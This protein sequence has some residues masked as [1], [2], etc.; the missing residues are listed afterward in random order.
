M[1]HA[2][3]TTDGLRISHGMIYYTEVDD[4]P[5]RTPGSDI[6]VAQLTLSTHDRHNDHVTTMNAQGKRKGKPSG[7]SS[8]EWSWV[9]YD[10][11]F[12]RVWQWKTPAPTLQPTRAPTALQTRSS[13]SGSGRALTLSPTPAA[14]KCGSDQ[15]Y[16]D[17]GASCA[18]C[19]RCEDS[20]SRAYQSRA[21]AAHSNTMCKKCST[22]PKTFYMVSECNATHNAVCRQCHAANKGCASLDGCSSSPCKHGGTCYDHTTT[23][24]CLCALGARIP[25]APGAGA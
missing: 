4:G 21:C 19:A 12:S 8:A 5:V 18:S 24:L 25:N 2:W 13:G 23:V 7:A 16:I 15:F 11:N 9:S 14:T 17:G 20:A 3:N 6:T 22:C 1:Y 10:L